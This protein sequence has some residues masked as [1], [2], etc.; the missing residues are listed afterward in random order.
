MPLFSIL[1]PTRNRSDLLADAVTSLLEQ[2]FPNLEVVVSDNSSVA[3]AERNRR[4]LANALRDSRCHYVRPPTEMS[5]ADHWEWATSHLK[6]QYLGIVTDRMALRLFA[7]KEIARLLSESS[8]PEVIC[9]GSESVREQVGY[10][11]LRQQS[12]F[13]ESIVVSTDDTA[14]QFSSG[15][16]SKDNPRMIN[17]FTRR[18]VFDR[19]RAEQGEVYGGIAPDYNFMFRILEQVSSYLFVKM[20]LL[21]TQGEDRSNGRAFAT[22]RSNAEFRDFVSKM[23][24]EQADLLRFGPIPED[25]SLITN[26]ILR[27]YD[28]VA[29]TSRSGRFVQLDLRGFHAEIAKTAAQLALNSSLS[30]TARATLRA[31]EAEHGFEPCDLPD[32]R[33]F[34]SLRK[35]LA[36]IHRQAFM[37]PSAPFRLAVDRLLLAAGLRSKISRRTLPEVLRV[38][39]AVR[40]KQLAVR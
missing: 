6:G 18:D 5:M 24:K 3:N 38:E 2:S 30:D 4:V 35:G 20:P 26:V 14:L 40:D 34:L 22:G 17:S 28:I 13:A 1:V 23:Q 31:F 39:A 9:F 19:L 27:E 37:R 25:I 8:W 10:L 33:A 32:P 36:Y 21:V 11:S 15:K 7:L 16:L 12:G 29:S